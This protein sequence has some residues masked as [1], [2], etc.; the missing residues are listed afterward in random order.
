LY[1]ATAENAALAGTVITAIAVDTPGN[2]TPKEVV[3]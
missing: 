1:T 3:L 2:E